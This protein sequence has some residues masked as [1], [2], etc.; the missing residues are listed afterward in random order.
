MRRAGGVRSERL[1]RRSICRRWYRG[2]CR[3]DRWGCELRSSSPATPSSRKRR[4]HFRT[5]WRETPN[6]RKTGGTRPWFQCPRPQCGRRC[7]ILCYVRGGGLICGACAASISEKRPMLAAPP[8]VDTVSS[9]ARTITPQSR[10]DLGEAGS[11]IKAPR[12]PTRATR[13]AAPRRELVENCL[14]VRV[15]QL[16]DRFGPPTYDEASGEHVCRVGR[17]LR[18]VML[19]TDP[20]LGGVRWWFACPACGARCGALYSPRSLAKMDLRCRAC[21]GLT[22]RSQLA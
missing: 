2:S 17:T 16:L 10:P 20:N 22:Y 4:L 1:G 8:R 12:P 6:S 11:A 18:I 9:T 5:V 3:G 13:V 7:A 15:E 21:W 19:T 14:L